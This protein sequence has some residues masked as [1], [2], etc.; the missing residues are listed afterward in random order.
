MW[1]G[2]PAFYLTYNLR[3]LRNSKANKYTSHSLNV[4]LS[5]RSSVDFYTTRNVG[6]QKVLFP[7][8]VVGM[9]KI[10]DYD[11]VVLKLTVLLPLPP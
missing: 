3:C 10:P 7:L 9:L 1:W 2:N 5:T 6:L 8:F 11:Y 4:M